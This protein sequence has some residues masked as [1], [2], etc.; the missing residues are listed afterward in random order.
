[1]RRLSWP[2]F[3]KKSW[4]A[5]ARKIF[6]CLSVVVVAGMGVVL[7][8]APRVAHDIAGEGHV[9]EWLTAHMFLAAAIVGIVLAVRLGLHNRPSPLGCF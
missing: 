7:V 2:P 9:F 6:L 5:A 4:M 8:G 1:M 3:I